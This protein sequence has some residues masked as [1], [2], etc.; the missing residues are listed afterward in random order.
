MS[1]AEHHAENT[2]FCNLISEQY[3]HFICK[4]TEERMLQS[5]MVRY[6]EICF[7]WWNTLCGDS[8]VRDR[9]EQYHVARRGGKGKEKDLVVKMRTYM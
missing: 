1:E 9:H 4:Y 3:I 2:N 5:I 7:D 6:F 8:N